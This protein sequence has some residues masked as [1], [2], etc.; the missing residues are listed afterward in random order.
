MKKTMLL[1]IVVGIC[2]AVIVAGGIIVLNLNNKKNSMV[3]K[4]DKEKRTL[5]KII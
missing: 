5:F 1:K 3:E 2:L 4:K